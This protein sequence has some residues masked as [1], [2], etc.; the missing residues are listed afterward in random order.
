MRREWLVVAIVSTG[1]LM[2]TMNTSIVNTLLPVIRDSFGSDLST[3]GW[4]LMSYTLTVSVL[5]LSF[6]RLGDIWGHRRV[7]NAGL[8]VFIAAS[9]LCA[10]SPTEVFLIAARSIQAVGGAM[11]V[12]NS[13]AV[14]AHSFLPEKRG[15][16]LAIY[17]SIG[18]LGVLIGPSLGGYLGGTFGWR[19]VFYVD[20][21]ICVLLAVLA[22]SIIPGTKAGDKREPFDFIGAGAFAIGLGALLLAIT[23]GQ[24]S[25]WGSTFIL[26][27]LASA[28]IFLAILVWSEWVRPYPMLDLRLFR[29][30]VFSLAIASNLVNLACVYAALFLMPFYLIQAR[31]FSPAMAGLLF[32][33][34]PLG[35]V[36]GTPISGYL[37]NRAGPRLLSTLGTIAVAAGL[38]TMHFLG[39]QS[40]NIEI[41]LPMAL[42]GL[43]N[44]L[45]VTPNAT[46][47][48]GSAPA[49]GQGVANG[50]VSTARNLGVVF[51][52]AIAG[53]ILSMQMAQ[54][55]AE[56]SDP[57]GLFIGAFQDTLLVVAMIAVM[58][59]ILA[60][61][62]RPAS[63]ASAH[64]RATRPL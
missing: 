46:T 1:A 11:L 43:G 45:F 62:G 12:S 10:L 49:E 50:I 37:C 18:S 38:F 33:A 4:V 64:S 20:V 34:E 27:S 55:I 5:L 35:V 3:I 6:G 22:F 16:L 24:E 36:V 14:L 21:L 59:A 25:G 9:G 7:Y 58:G 32:S 17:Y 26:G 23:K 56:Q 48:L 52:V 54:R 47:I 31:G 41:M 39:P 2:G 61:A 44:G 60:L 19:S 51:G 29:S 28:V 63:R 42:I 15:Q 40:G 8:L 30:R 53:A 13:Q 57:Q